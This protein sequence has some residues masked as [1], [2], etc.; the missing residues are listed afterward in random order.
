MNFYE[1]LSITPRA[2]RDEIRKRYLELV[3]QVHP[4]KRAHADVRNIITAMKFDFHELQRAWKTL[5]NPARRFEYDMEIFGQSLLHP[6]KDES[7]L[8]HLR[9]T[10]AAAAVERMSTRYQRLLL[11]EV[12][13]PKGLIVTLA[14]YAPYEELLKASKRPLEPPIGLSKAVDVLIPVQCLV[15]QHKIIVGGGKTCTKADITG[16]YSPILP[17][18]NIEMGLLIRYTFS[19]KVHQA[20][21]RDDEPL[22]IPKKTHVVDISALGPGGENIYSGARAGSSPPSSCKD[23]TTSSELPAS[24]SLPMLKHALEAATKCV[25]IPMQWAH[26]LVMPHLP[27]SALSHMGPLFLLTACCA[28]FGLSTTTV[29]SEKGAFTHTLAVVSK[30]L[31]SSV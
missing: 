16:F 24:R 9:M 13:A 30:K 31:A 5:K 19:G 8:I 18:E 23:R 26:T 2:S 17:S 7:F 15:E 14:L 11:Y 29:L 20:I 3:I 28:I 1:L 22:W 25:S 6:D 10:E 27:S 12:G 4:D 21:V